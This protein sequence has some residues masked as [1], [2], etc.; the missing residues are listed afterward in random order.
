MAGKRFL[1]I[2]FETY[3]SVDIAKCGS[4]KYLESPDFEILL[5]AFAFDDD[6]VALIDHMSSNRMWHPELHNALTDPNVIK[7]AHNV[8]FERYAIQ[9]SMGIYSPP[10]QWFDTM[11]LAAQCGLPMSLDAI[12]KALNLPEDQAK[13]KEGK[14]LIRYFCLPCKPTKKNGM[15]TRNLPEHDP[16]KWQKF[17][18]YCGRDVEV[19]RTI[20]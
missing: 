5:T 17:G 7:V 18:D 15:R 2:D 11:H 16:E 6:P 4:F 14:A 8:S 3:S 19:M 10:E 1:F 20:F 12:G 13:M 9:R